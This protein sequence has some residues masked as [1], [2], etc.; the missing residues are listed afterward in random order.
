MIVTELNAM[1]ARDNTVHHF[2]V[3][4]EN[5]DSRPHITFVSR[6]SVLLLSKHLLYPD[7]SNAPYSSLYADT[8]PDRFIYKF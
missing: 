2:E 7:I 3:E 6:Q 5:Y 1:P 8:T 4:S